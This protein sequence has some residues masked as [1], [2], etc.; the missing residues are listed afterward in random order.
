MAPKPYPRSPPNEFLF[1]VKGVLE[2]VRGR[3]GWPPR[4]A[5]VEVS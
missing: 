5:M 4:R 2:L 3:V 1:V